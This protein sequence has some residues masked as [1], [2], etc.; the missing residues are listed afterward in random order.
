MR[1]SDWSSDVC[2][3]DLVVDLHDPSG[4]DCLRQGAPGRGA[5]DP[6]IV[7]LDVLHDAQIGA[8]DLEARFLNDAPGKPRPMQAD[9]I[10]DLVGKLRRLLSQVRDLGSLRY[11][12]SIEVREEENTSEFQ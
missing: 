4:S 10:E 2:S 6:I 9:N 8:H 11:V 12:K 5:D 7:E 3:S 1:I